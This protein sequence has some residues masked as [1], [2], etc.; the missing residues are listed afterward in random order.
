MRIEKIDLEHPM[1]FKVSVA[2]CIG[3]FDGMH[4][5][6]QQLFH[7]TVAIAEE[8]KCETALITFDCDPWSVVKGMKNIQ[9]ISTMRQRINLAV[10]YGIQNIYI[11]KFTK[12]MSELSPDDFL[13]KVLGMCNIE[14]L[15]CGFDF[16]YGKFGA[17][18]A[19]I[20]KETA[21]FDV[22]I[23]D[24]I[25][26]NGEK[27]SSTRISNLIID[28]DIPQVNRLL[29]YRFNIEGKV[30]H[31]KRRGTVIGFPTANIEYSSEYLL[32]KLGVY[33]GY[34]VIY[35]KH[36]QAMI[37][38]GHNPTFNY[39][40][41]VSFEVHI[42]GFKGNIYGKHIT[43]EFVQYLREEKK[44]K[45]IDNLIMQLEQDVCSVRKILK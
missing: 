25:L 2:A 30:I 22:H 41:K 28:G 5:G 13:T 23:I 9:H 29:G 4:L 33:A 19:N 16:H 26:D 44:F 34:A 12:E 42:L 3:Y 35:G 1:Q 6:H 20:L 15:V 40:E 24:A 43:I 10:K 36:Y 39:N 17:G 31:G 45:N 8:K 32:P 27:I 21:S 37:N 7:K 11:L 14:A 18:N 38:L